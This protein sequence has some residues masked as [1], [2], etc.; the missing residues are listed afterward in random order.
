MNRYREEFSE[1]IETD[2][3]LQWGTKKSVLVDKYGWVVPNERLISFLRQY[4][5]IL[6]IGSGCG[7][8]SF[9]VNRESDIIYPTDIAVPDDSWTT[10]YEQS[11]RDIYVNPESVPTTDVVL[12]SWP[13]ADSSLV[14]DTIEYLEPS[15]YVYI[16]VLDSTITGS[17]EDMSC[18]E[19]NRYRLTSQIS[20]NGW[21]PDREYVYCFKKD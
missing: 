10:V 8:L 20:V 19:L 15:V 7:Y 6:E 5:S 14:I 3:D 4:D 12:C 18:F 13:P 17:E 1:K 16:G 2:S 9:E 21:L 11:L